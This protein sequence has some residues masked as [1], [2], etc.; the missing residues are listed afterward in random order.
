MQLASTRDIIT[1][2]PPI[3]HAPISRRILLL[4]ESS[5]EESIRKLLASPER[6][7]ETFD[8]V[9]ELLEELRPESPLRHRLT[10]EIDE[11][12]ELASK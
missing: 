4:S 5:V 3:P 8:K 10:Q 11:L 6:N 12:R 1:A 2:L 9:E 7:E